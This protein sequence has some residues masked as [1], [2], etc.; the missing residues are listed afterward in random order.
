MRMRP[1]EMRNET[2]PDEMRWDEMRWEKIRWEEMRW[3][4]MR[5]EEKRRAEQRREE[6][7]KEEQRRRE[8]R[9]DEIEWDAMRCWPAMLKAL[10]L[11]AF[12]LLLFQP[13][14]V[15]ILTLPPSTSSDEHLNF[16]WHQTEVVRSHQFWHLWPAQTHIKLKDTKLH[17]WGYPVL[18]FPENWKVSGVRSLED[19]FIPLLLFAAFWNLVGARSPPQKQRRETLA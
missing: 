16:Q 14:R 13:Y 1:D 9:R 19:V 7:R 8:E 10:F 18:L 11:N 12:V 3:D 5:R 17:M 6:K 15:S 4:E 2:E